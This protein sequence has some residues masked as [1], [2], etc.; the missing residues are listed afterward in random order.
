MG[1]QSV[2]HAPTCS[3]TTCLA[4]VQHQ[5]EITIL[6]VRANESWT[7]TEDTLVTRVEPYVVPLGASQCTGSINN[8]RT[9]F[10]A[11]ETWCKQDTQF[12]KVYEPWRKS[13]SDYI[14]DITAMVVKYMLRITQTL[15]D[16][17]IVSLLALYMLPFSV[18]KRTRAVQAAEE[19]KI[20][21]QGATY[22][23]AGITFHPFAF[24]VP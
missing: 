2:V 16:L 10:H 4:C 11:F 12:C 6:L 7:C 15:L 14:C 24:R 18:R 23:A 1:R 3:T 21:N 22:S 5:E 19:R 8:A 9:I 20:Q 13:G 17:I